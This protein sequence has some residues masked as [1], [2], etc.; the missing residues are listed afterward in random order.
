MRNFIL[1]SSNIV[2]NTNNSKLVYQF[3]GGGITIKKG[4]KVALASVQMYYST[5]N[6]SAAQGNNVFNY[7]W[8][9]GTTNVITIPDGFYDADGLNNYLRFEMLANK[10]YLTTIATGEIVYFLAISTNSTFY[11]IQLD[12]FIMNTTLFPAATYAL[13][14]GATWVVP[15]G[16]ASP[17]PMFQILNNAF[18]EIIGFAVGFYPQGN[19]QPPNTPAVVPYGTT[20]YGA[21]PTYIQAPA[22]TTN[23]AFISKDSGLVPQ[24]TPLSSYIL[25]C[26][27]VNNTFAVP[28][29]LLYSFAPV[30]AFG[31]QFTI[32]PNQYV[33][34]D[35]NDGLFTAF[36]LRFTDQNNFPVAIQDPNYVIMII[37]ADKNEGGFS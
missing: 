4:Q 5:F 33:F 21:A 8:F 28:N 19:P 22:Y 31:S 12:C 2:P 29:N 15:T 30:G 24:I 34:I 35:A 10:H 14:A 13:P 11:S 16:A 1:N 23:Q 20:T 9:D 36:E 26:N 7:V 6:I 17:C 32:A 3:S 37:I 27:L 18:K 25:T